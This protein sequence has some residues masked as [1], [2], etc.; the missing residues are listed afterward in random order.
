MRFPRSSSILP[1]RHQSLGAE[2]LITTE[3][4]A[5]RLEGLGSRQ[6]LV[7]FVFLLKFR[8]SIVD[9]RSYLQRVDKGTKVN[10]PRLRKGLNAFRREQRSLVRE[11]A[12][13][14]LS[15]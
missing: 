12:Q 1:T 8:N 14:R 11:S 2:V 13:S 15:G 3:K 5:V 10:S 6:L 9:W 7:S 4:D